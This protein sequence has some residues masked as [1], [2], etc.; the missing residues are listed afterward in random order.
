VDGRI[1]IITAMGLDKLI[2]GYRA[3]IEQIY[4]PLNITSGSDAF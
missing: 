2:Y 3:I 4:S 1:N